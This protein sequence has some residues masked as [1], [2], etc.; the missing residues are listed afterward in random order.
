MAR[1]QATGTRAFVFV[2][3]RTDGT[4]ADAAAVHDMQDACTVRACGGASVTETT[5][6]DS[7]SAGQPDK[8]RITAPPE[9]PLE[10]LMAVTPG[11]FFDAVRTLLPTN[12]P[13]DAARLE[14]LCALEAVSVP[15]FARV[16]AHALC[17]AAHLGRLP[18]AAGTVG[19]RRPGGMVGCAGAGKRGAEPW[20]RALAAVWWFG[21]I[22]E[23]VASH[24]LAVTD[25]TG[26]ALDGAR[27]YRC[28]IPST[29][30]WTLAVYDAWLGLLGGS[31]VVRGT[32]PRLY[33]E[34]DGA[35]V[36]NV[37]PRDPADATRAA[38]W[39]PTPVGTNFLLV[40]RAYE[41]ASVGG[42][43]GDLMV[44]L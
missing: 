41:V 20:D 17:P 31:S 34:A 6:D 38:Q 24:Y 26:Q 13:P 29:G 5:E 1:R 7:K 10:Y 30:D 40:L 25:A 39:L 21:V 44:A 42:G 27:T 2:S 14:A 23:A 11:A 28:R 12:P 36:V 22:P 15:V 9:A 33:R 37:G 32:D 18:R 3:F 16:R 19:W 4:D 8:D 43:P 35:V